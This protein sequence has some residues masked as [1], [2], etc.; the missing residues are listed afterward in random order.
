MLGVLA[1]AEPEAPAILAPGGTSVESAELA[2]RIA[3]LGVVLAEHGLGR[4][5]RVA[6]VAGLGPVAATALLGV[7]SRATCVPVNPDGEG[8]VAT[9]LRRTGA[10]ALLAPSGA[11]DGLREAADAEGVVL[12]DGIPRGGSDAEGALARVRD[13]PKPDD[14]ALILRTSGTTGTPKLVPA[15]HRQLAARAE[16]AAETLGI[17]PGDRCLCPMPLCYGHGIYSGL[18]FSLLTGGSV[19]LP[20][21]SDEES[22]IEALT[23]LRPTWYT[24]G[25]THHEAIRGWL[26]RLGPRPAGHPL[27]FARC[28]NA[29]LPTETRDELEQLLAAPVIETYGTSETGVIASERP[30]AQ[31]RAGAMAPPDG[32]EVTIL[33]EGGSPLEAGEAGA[34]AVRGPNVFSGYEGDAELNRRA[35]KRDWFLTG[36]AGSLDAGGFLTIDGRLDEVINRGGEKVAPAEV[37]SALLEHPAVCEAVVF[38]IPHRTLGEDLAAVVRPQAGREPSPRE[39]RAHLTARL[40]RFKVPR[41][42]A[43]VDTVP[44]G[45]TGKPLRSVMAA[46]LG[47]EAPSADGDGAE[48]DL[49]ERRLGSLW[50]EAL[51]DDDA[52]PGQDFFDLG[53]DSLAAVALLAAIE[54][55]LDVALGLDDLLEAPTPRSLARR[56]RRSLAQ[57][58]GADNTRRSAVGV[59]TSG[60]LTPLFAVPGRPGYALRVLLLGR[61]LGS[62]QPVYGLQPPAMDW[63]AIGVGSLPEMAAHHLER[64]REIQP[65]GPYRLLGSSFGGLLAFEMA[66][67]LERAGDSVEFLG[68]IDTKPAAF[69]RRWA[70]SPMRRLRRWRGEPD[71]E[72]AGAV[73]AT[74][75]RTAA[76]HAAARRSYAIA[77]RVDTEITL[78]V[79][80]SEGVPA[81]GERR[82]LWAD[83]TAGGLRVVALPG[84]HAQFDHEPQFSALRDAL[85][86]C[87]AGDE[88]PGAADPATVLR[89]RFR[90]ERN[91]D[92]EAIVEPGGAVHRVEHGA[93]RGQVSPALPRRGKLLLRGWAGDPEGGLPGE[94]VVAFLGGRFAGY[95]HC[96]A[97]TEGLARRLEAPGL[98]HA[99]FRL[100]LK[101]GRGQSP[102]TPRVFALAPDGRASELAG[103][104]RAA[105]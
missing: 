42:I 81:E 52:G 14:V 36:D 18:L 69:A 80:T 5:D 34:I 67:Q 41:R 78:F 9:V 50:G 28:A 11:T 31:P 59:H 22:F 49:L 71:P 26:R 27:R 24:A 90:L 47:H 76:I 2:G 105:S 35:F 87:L 63:E 79:C 16:Q 20:E 104:E 15:T 30:S 83:A 84:R 100:W 55:E 77:D 93:M 4:P 94:T 58:D 96:G 37:E 45:P 68:M 70:I 73:V 23:T 19:I 29:S 7:A 85:R 21:R 51:D 92:G 48:A 82:H 74:G 32:V 86:S 98:R 88:P 57:A 8:E 95:S 3:D 6:V 72:D 102:P 97:P 56:I 43:L 91:P 10:R 13:L 12:L 33:G 1:E 62:A 64:I 46:S 44:R 38:A 65:R 66:R 25:P 17:G 53:G 103:R 61:E 101:P 40:A 99:G 75:T 39:L 54:E 89:R 60:A